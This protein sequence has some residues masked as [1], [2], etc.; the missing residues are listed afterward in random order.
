[1]DKVNNLLQQYTK[2]KSEFLEHSLPA[3][4]EI[5]AALT[6]VYKQS[7]ISNYLDC[8]INVGDITQEEYNEIKKWL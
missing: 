3:N 1:M 6:E 8:A 5:I 2:G 7:F 4:P